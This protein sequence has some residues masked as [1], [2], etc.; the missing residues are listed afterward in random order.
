MYTAEALELRLTFSWSRRTGYGDGY[1]YWIDTRAGSVLFWLS[2]IHCPH[3]SDFIDK[4]QI[5]VH[6]WRES[7]V[8]IFYPQ[9]KE[10]QRG[11]KKYV[12][13]QSYELAC[14][15]RKLVYNLTF[16]SK[17]CNNNYSW[18]PNFW[19]NL[20]YVVL[21]SDNHLYFTQNPKIPQRTSNTI[22]PSSKNLKF[23]S[24]WISSA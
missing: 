9:M 2:L 10:V 15:V 22:S 7:G 1:S 14:T 16:K 21:K 20:S 13:I 3:P 11:T 5:C 19:Q 23:T 24:T 17:Y 8:L 12:E 4:V 18:N 6:R